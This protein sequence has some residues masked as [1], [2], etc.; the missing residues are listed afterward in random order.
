MI[1]KYRL[2]II[3]PFALLTLGISFATSQSM[4]KINEAAR[5]ASHKLGKVDV[6]HN[7]GEFLITH[8]NKIHVVENHCVDKPL[9]NIDKHKLA[10]FLTHGHLAINKTDNGEF[11]IR[12]NTHLKGGGVIGATVG[13]FL[14]KAAVSVV[15]HGTIAIVSGTVGF[16]CPPAGWALAV[17]LESTCGP[18]IEAAS[19]QGAIAGG[20]AGGVATGPV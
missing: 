19:L 2:V 4:I 15:G 16:F 1:Q 9:R 20:I 11:T 5:F 17:S 6:Y 12:G 10:M 13:A 8:N 14:G 7:N 18:M 3:A